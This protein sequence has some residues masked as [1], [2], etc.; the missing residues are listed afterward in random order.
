MPNKYLFQKNFEGKKY[1]VVLYHLDQFSFYSNCNS[2]KSVNKTIE[3]EMGKSVINT[4][5][6]CS[7]Y[8]ITKTLLNLKLFL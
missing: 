6:N 1:F 2:N 5:K 8:L 7:G 4:S 3:N